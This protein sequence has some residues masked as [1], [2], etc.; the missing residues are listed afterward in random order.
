MSNK[1]RYFVVSFALSCTVIVV[2]R[3][4]RKYSC[5]HVQVATKK[6]KPTTKK[7]IR[8]IQK[9]I[10]K[11]SQNHHCLTVELPTDDQKEQ[12][13]HKLTD[14]ETSQI[15]TRKDNTSFLKYC[16]N[17]L[18][19]GHISGKCRN[20]FKL[21]VA[22][23][24]HTAFWGVASRFY[25]N[26]KVARI[27]ISGMSAQGLSN[28]K[29][30]SQSSKS[31][32]SGFNKC[33]DG[34]T[35]YLVIQIGQVDIDYVWYF[36]QMKYKNTLH[37][38]DQIEMSINHL[39]SFLNDNVSKHSNQNVKVIIHGVHPPPL[40][41]EDMKQKLYHHFT[42][43]GKLSKQYLDDNLVLP[44]HKERTQMALRFNKRLKQKCD[45]CEGKFV[46]VDISSEIVDRN[47]GI[48]D[49]KYLKKDEIDIHLNPKSLVPVYH[50][51]FK[52]LNLDFAL[53]IDA[54]W[55]KVHQFESDLKQRF[56]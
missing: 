18:Q 24:S 33:H 16:A 8:S 1:A 19:P 41:N 31:I 4:L 10:I 39:L 17:C 6:R 12:Y 26:T 9:R 40:S 45:E 56:C 7:R 14:M 52:A 20:R 43:R 29:S 55:N 37:F 38:D 27:R 32:L 48:V 28:T 47:T 50:T 30:H 36:R 3:V 25:I 42:N 21:C 51:K 49:A 54:I 15:Q 5:N 34:N 44:S 46:C 53:Q 22:G 2:Y 11:V 35:G 23:D 13:I